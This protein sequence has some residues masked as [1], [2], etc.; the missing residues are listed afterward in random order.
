MIEFVEELQEDGNLL[1]TWNAETQ[2]EWKRV[3]Y[4]F[5]TMIPAKKWDKTKKSW[6]VDSSA[7]NAFRE[8]KS[9]LSTDQGAEILSEFDEH[10]EEQTLLKSTSQTMHW[11]GGTKM[12]CRA[13]F[14]IRAA[15]SIIDAPVGYSISRGVFGAWNE[16]A[17]VW[18]YEDG[19]YSSHSPADLDKLDLT[20]AHE[21]MALAYKRYS[22]DLERLDEEMP[23]ISAK[24]LLRL[25]ML[26]KY[27]YQCY[28]CS[29]RPDN[30]SELHMHRVVSEKKG[31]TYA[32][33]NVVILCRKHHRKLEGLDWDI[34]HKAKEEYDG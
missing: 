28:V 17:G 3:L 31:G 2:G 22:D 29:V 14:A 4:A 18:F 21:R 27:D 12:Q 33:E 10:I 26:R 5:K 20:K 9:V 23:S 1:V 11:R 24:Q 7:I 8:F 16:E 13:I 6:I 30:L 34:V 19:R 15:M 25:A 32:E